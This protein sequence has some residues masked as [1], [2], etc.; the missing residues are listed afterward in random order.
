VAHGALRVLLGAALHSDP[1]S[2]TYALT[3]GV[4]GSHEHGRPEVE[5]AGPLSF[6][7]SHSGTVG[8]IAVAEAKVGAD[9]EVV[10]PRRHLERVAARVM[11][12]GAFERWSALPE[13]R[14]IEAFLE[15]WTAKEAFLKLLGVGLTQPLRDVD[16]ANVATWAGW[17]AGCVTSVATAIPVAPDAWSRSTFRPIA[18]P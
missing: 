15:T 7:L 14:R 17:P 3:C 8:V 9:V 11:P 16:P 1:A 4:C 2:I 10:R 6:S 13:P 12:A 5:G 18:P